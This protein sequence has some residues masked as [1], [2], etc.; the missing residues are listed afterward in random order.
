MLIFKA[1]V[2]NPFKNSTPQTY[3]KNGNY[4][5]AIAIGLPAPQPR[6]QK[7]SPGLGSAN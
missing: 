7:I 2:Y 4:K 5:E 1:E 6:S 3:F